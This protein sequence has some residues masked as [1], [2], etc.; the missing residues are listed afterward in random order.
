[1]DR[2]IPLLQ[3][4]GAAPSARPAH[5]SPRYSL[6]VLFIRAYLRN[7]A[8]VT[9]AICTYRPGRIAASPERR[10]HL[11]QLERGIKSDAF[12]ML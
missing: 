12:H 11:R 7:R 2:R 1:M 9:T 5:H 10:R 4:A 3:T 6:A 8:G